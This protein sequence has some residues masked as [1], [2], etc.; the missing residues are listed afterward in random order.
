MAIQDD[1]SVAVNGDIRY[2]GTTANYTVI[3]LHR[4]LQDLADDAVS[5]GNDLHDITDDTSSDRSTDNIITINA[6]YNIDATLATH[7][8]DGSITQDN[9]NTIFA[10]LVVV[11]SVETGTN[12][13]IVQNNEVLTDTWTAFPN[14]DPA[15]NILMRTTIQTRSD[16][17]NI[18]GQRIIIKAR[19]YGDTY[20]EFSVTMALGNNT[21]ALFTSADLNNQ[22]ASGTVGA[23][24]KI[25][26]T[27]GFQLLEI[28]GGAPT[29]PYFSQWQ[30]NG[31][32]SLPAS[33]KIND[34]YEY[35]KY[36]QRRGTA[37]TIHGMNGDLFR[38]ITHEWAYDGIVGAEPTTNETFVWGTFL[39]VGVI[40]GTYTVGEVV[41][42]GTS[43]ALGRVLSVDATN[44][45]LVIATE[46]GTWVSGEVVTGVTSGA[47]ATSSSGPVGQATGGGAAVILAADSVT[48]DKVWIQ[49]IKGT[50]PA[51][52]TVTY[53]DTDHT[54]SN[55]V[56][57]AVTSRAVSAPF[58]GNST[59]SALL[60]AFGI[61][62]DPS[63]A[64]ASDLFIDLEG[65]AITPPNN[66]TFTVSG[67][68]SGEDR[69][70]VGPE[71]GGSLNEAQFTTVGNITTDNITAVTVNTA[72]PT[73]TPSSGTIRVYDDN[74]IARRLVYSSYT[75]SVFTIDPT[76]SE[77]DVPN[78]ADFSGVNATAGNNA[79]ISYIDKLA[80]GTSVSFTSV[81][82]SARALFIRV[83]DG[84]ASPI[85]TFE[86]TGS[87]G[88][89]GG[90]STAIRTTDA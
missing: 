63:D 22:T 88:S 20:A 76:A 17:V 68:I 12:I 35:A 6:P 19:E 24:D 23:Y 39:D 4:F 30:V 87:L 55:D 64:G 37:E 45:S 28:S 16:G 11:G 34:V 10:G 18:N 66:V 27:E 72:I 25:D 42:G 78:V 62:L 2:T 51:D 54:R 29:E 31:A 73:D 7:L 84:G 50:A 81:F 3:E 79:Y 32:G 49:L 56:A 8:Y 82:L 70:L 77:A 83:R 36:I 26:N 47:T 90:S 58:I 86:T 21:A 43:G 71:S 48:D 41:S 9:G 61:G 60:G 40:T 13:I 46:T 15:A 85:K 44:T 65:N 80:D 69:V 57:G 74:G 53:E 14:A 38:G 1:I 75:G 67:L 33:P 89:A 59:G 52:N 5:S